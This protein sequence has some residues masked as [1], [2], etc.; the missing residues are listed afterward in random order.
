MRFRQ[1]VWTVAGA[2]ILLVG[3]GVAAME[4]AADP[5][6][7]TWK[8]EQVDFTYI[9]RTSFYTCDALS[10]KVAYILRAAGARDDLVVRGIGCFGTSSF[11]SFTR[12][13]IKVAVP[14]VAEPG[15]MPADE[16]SR[17]E[18]VARVRGEK[19]TEEDL[20]GQFPAEW[21]TVRLTGRSS[22]VDDGDCELLEQMA[23]AV[24]KPLGI[25][26]TR[27][28]NRCIPGEVRYGQLDF[29]FKALKALP[30]PDAR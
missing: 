1:A 20:L 27:G 29:Q 25:E 17:K 30:T 14:V 21:Q 18:L 13:R 26:V 19:P 7:A 15:G 16:R 12:V 10:Q 8:E 2:M 3:G 24:F 23:F 4:P 9:G 5:V 28:K 11:D 22:I 6:I